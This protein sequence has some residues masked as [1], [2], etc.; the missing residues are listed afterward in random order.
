[1]HVKVLVVSYT[2][3]YARVG[4]GL[5]PWAWRLD[6][7]SRDTNVNKCIRVFFNPACFLSKLR[8][9]CFISMCLQGPQWK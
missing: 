7:R 3:P 6:V 4:L 8:D 1:M 9:I 2:A 5:V